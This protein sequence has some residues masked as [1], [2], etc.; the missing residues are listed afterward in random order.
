MKKIVIS[1]FILLNLGGI[2]M[3][4]SR[5][6]KPFKPEK[7]M[8]ALDVLQGKATLKIGQKAY[9]KHALHGSV[10][11]G[12]DLEIADKSKIKIIKQHTAY[13]KA[14]QVGMTGDD[15]AT[16]TLVLEALEKGETTITLKKIFRGTVE[17]QNDIQIT[18]VE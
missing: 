15:A 17:E 3:A 14:H 6:L 18:I 11:I 4:Q 13:K 8:V 7:N 10:G 5:N 2:L 16:V 1:L 12:G 9:I